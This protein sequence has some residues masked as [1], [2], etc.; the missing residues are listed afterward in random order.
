MP[1]ARILSVN[2]VHEIRDDPGYG[3]RT[4]IDKR[5]TDRQVELRAWGL[6]GDTVMDHGDHGGRDQAVYAYAAE[7][8]A[9]WG[10]ELGRD[11]RPGTFGENLTTEGVDVTGAVVGEQ[12]RVAGADGADVLLQ[13]TAPR[14]PCLT[15]QAWVEEPHWVKRFTDH[16]APGAYLRVLRPGTLRSG[17][18]VEVVERPDHGVTIGEVFQPRLADPERLRAL[19]DQQDDLHPGLVNAVQKRLDH[20][21]LDPAR[22]D[23]A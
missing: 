9:W 7:D 15:F 14:I 12:W 20:V 3:A 16:G 2:L 1:D 17:A 21:T 13:V 19:L 22:L 10:G 23:R 6:Y 4:A 18:A 11:L 5:G 8:L